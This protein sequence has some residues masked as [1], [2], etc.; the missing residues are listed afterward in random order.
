MN[1][2][3]KIFIALIVIIF[4]YIFWRLITKRNQIIKNTEPFSFNIIPDSANSDLNKLKDKIIKINMNSLPTTYH[5]LPLMDFCIKGSY[6]SAYTGKYINIDM[7]IYQLSRGCRFFD[8]EVFYIENPESR[9]F[10][11]QVAYSTDANFVSMDCENSILL[12]NVLSALISNCFSTQ[13]APNNKDPLF[14]NLRIKS[15][16]DKVYKAVASSVDYTIKNKLYTG[17]ITKNTPMK[18]LMGKIVLCIDKTVNYKYKDYTNCNQDDKTCYN[19]KNYTNI[20][21]GSE[22]MVLNRY[23]NVLNQ[24]NV[25]LMIKDNNLNTN[26][27]N[28]NLVLPDTIPENA[29][30][31]E[32]QQFIMDY[33]CQIVPF[34]FYQKDEGLYK[35]EEFFN[36]TNGGTVPLSVAIIYFKK[37]NQ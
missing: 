20:E 18:D 3:K 1:I 14:I 10:S 6:N 22:N 24:K 21:S 30:N 32:I 4:S 15:N 26:V 12:D 31:P 36:D 25:K 13:N 29:P 35:Y 33:G 8:F 34:K 9:I 11:P 28:M 37:K 27:E 7:L 23:I 2:Y 17:K 5:S 19:L 16:N